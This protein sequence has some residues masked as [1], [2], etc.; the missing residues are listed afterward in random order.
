M[1]TIRTTE[2]GDLASV[3]ALY[4]AVAETPGGL[5]RL[6]S[7]VDEDYVRSFLDRALKDGLSLVALNDRGHLVGE[8]HGYRPGLYCFSHVL[9]ELTIAVS[10]DAQGSG[11]G[12]QLFEGFMEAV[13]AW[14][15]ITRVELI[16]RESND[17]A[18]RFYESLG[19]S[20]EGR[21]EGRIRNVDG[22][23]EADVPMAWRR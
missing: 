9:S 11:V 15:E 8:I 7:E 4:R 20:V 17:R 23:F 18:I 2:R 21:L 1:L 12:R 16:A 22:S 19:F 13:V 6:S 3:L 14:P 10:P 5:A